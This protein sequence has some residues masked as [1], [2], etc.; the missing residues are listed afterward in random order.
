MFYYETTKKLIVAFST[1]FDDVF[2]TTEG[3]KT[4]KV[5]LSYAPKEKF[6][7]YFESFESLDATAH[8]H[9]LPRMGFEMGSPSFDPERFVNPLSQ[10][11]NFIHQKD[12]WF[13]A[14]A[15]YNFPF[16]L[17]IGTKKFEDSLRIIEQILPSFT[18]EL[19]V[20]I[21]D[22]EH[23]DLSTDVPFVLESV[24][25][26]ISYE[27]SFEDHRTIMWTLE[28]NARAWIYGKLNRQQVI[29][30]T[31]VNFSNGETNE[32]F[33]KLMSEVVPFEASRT[34]DHKIKDTKTIYST[35]ILDD[36]DGENATVKYT[37]DDLEDDPTWTQ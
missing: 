2:I 20:T 24:D 30:K 25:M 15:P 22:Q 1:I 7:A 3:D 31:T 4:I 23:L 5:P 8:R 33:L 21:K 11:K 17:Y 19:N 36:A 34:D 12:E 35:S 37:F 27:D 6:V 29:K 16:T 10:M 18:P 32:I 14:R 28:F 9:T 13:Y 26:D